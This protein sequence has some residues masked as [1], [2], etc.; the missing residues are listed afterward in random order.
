MQTLYSIEKSKYKN[1]EVI[2]VNNNSQDGTKE[3]LSWM[4]ENSGVAVI[5]N[6]TVVNSDVN[7]WDWGGMIEGVKHT[8]E[9]SEYIV[10]LDNDIKIQNSGRLT[11]MKRV[12]DNSDYKITMCDFGHFPKALLK[13]EGL[14]SRN[15]EW[16]T[17]NTER[18]ETATA[19]YMVRKSDFLEVIEEV[20]KEKGLNS[21][22]L[23]TKKLGGC[24]FLRSI[25]VELQ[26]YD[27]RVPIQQVK[28]PPKNKFIHEKI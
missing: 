27:T 24:A 8:S 17:V 7:H 10:Q 18:V 19:C 9:D 2:I 5:K 15:V 1:Y 3:W 14:R 13:G 26:D 22:P 23:M 25:N 6:T 28:Y 16:Y 20:T 4:K 11:F 21:K 12:L